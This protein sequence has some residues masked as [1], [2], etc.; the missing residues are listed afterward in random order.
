MTSFV[1][2]T[3]TAGRMVY[4]FVGDSRHPPPCKECGMPQARSS[5]DAHEAKLEKLRAKMLGDDDE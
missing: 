3:C 4:G 1:D 5:D 2:R